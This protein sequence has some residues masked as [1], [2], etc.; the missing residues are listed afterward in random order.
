MRLRFLWTDYFEEASKAA[1][2][3]YQRNQ[4]PVTVPSC[5]LPP[6]AGCAA[7]VSSWILPDLLGKL[8]LVVV[9]STLDMQQLCIGMVQGL[10][11][12]AVLPRKLVRP[13]AL[14]QRDTVGYLSKTDSPPQVIL[15]RNLN[16]ECA[17]H[18]ENMTLDLPQQND[19]AIVVVSKVT[20]RIGGYV[21]IL[22]SQLLDGLG[23]RLNH[24]YLESGKKS[25]LCHIKNALTK[26]PAANL[27]AE[28]KLVSNGGNHGSSMFMDESKLRLPVLEAPKMEEAFGSWEMPSLS[29]VV[30][31]RT[32]EMGMQF[33]H[34]QLADI[35]NLLESEITQTATRIF[36]NKFCEQSPWHSE[37]FGHLCGSSHMQLFDLLSEDKALANL[38]STRALCL[39]QFRLLELS[40]PLFE[41]DKNVASFSSHIFLK[42]FDLPHQVVCVHTPTIL[43]FNPSE[44]FE[45]LI[46]GPELVYKDDIFSS[47]PVPALRENETSCIAIDAMQ[48]AL[49]EYKHAVPLALDFLYLDW[50]FS[51]KK[52]CGKQPCSVLEDRLLGLA[53]INL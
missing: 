48:E 51:Q 53:K 28:S 31:T 26:D 46:V 23:D 40:I 7:L 33:G 25:P 2:E 44:T 1:T 14:P 10:F 38:L 20:N 3:C 13:W 12:S 42:V 16:F 39:K 19:L 32:L 17:P 21:S 29:Q 43:D 5:V 27:Q 47:L 41:V 34:M 4:L 18:F 15:S 22:E 30:Y 35:L 9:D 45:T 52:V 24:F 50:H 11:L 49:F 8:P 37:N 36:T 6:A